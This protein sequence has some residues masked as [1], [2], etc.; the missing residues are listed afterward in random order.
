M[1]SHSRTAEIRTHLYPRYQC[2]SAR[3]RISSPSLFVLFSEFT[4]IARKCHTLR[5][6]RAKT[7]QRMDASAFSNGRVSYFDPGRRGSRSRSKN[8]VLLL[9]THSAAYRNMAADQLCQS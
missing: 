7:P 6:A 2:R 3:V 4:S 9:D 8:G 1:L 5:I